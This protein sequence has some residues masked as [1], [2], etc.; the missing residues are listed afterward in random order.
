M[1][2]VKRWLLMSLLIVVGLGWPAIGHAQSLDY[3]ALKYG[4]SQ[5]SMAGKYFVHPAKVQVVQHAY[6]VTMEIKTAKHLNKWP[7]RVLKIAGQTPQ[8]VQKSRD[9]AGNY[10]LFYTFTTTHLNRDI[11]AKLA[12]NVLG[13]Y[14]ATHKLTL[15]FQTADL[16]ALSQSKSATK[17]TSATKATTAKRTQSTPANDSSQKPTSKK[18]AAS[19]SAAAASTTSSNSSRAATS[20]ATASQEADAADQVPKQKT[21]WMSLLGGS[22]AIVIVVLGGSWWYFGRH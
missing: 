8:N 10:L 18:K 14:K 6:Q 20:S 12:I 13:V 21:N 15:A 11:T 3:T 19:A 17:P 5:T 4:T 16:P 9:S 7:V 2:H 1:K 22:L